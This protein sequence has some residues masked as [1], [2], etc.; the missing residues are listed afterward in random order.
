VLTEA[1]AAV[2]AGGADVELCTPTGAAILAAA[3]TRWQSP[4]ALTPLAVGYGAGDRE[5]ADRPNVLRLTA[6]SPLTS[7]E[8]AV[9]LLEANVDDMSPEIAAHAALAVTAAGA[10]DVWWTP[11]TMKKG[12]PGWV[13]SALTPVAAAAAVERA[14]FAETTTIGVRIAPVERRTAER[15]VVTVETAL[16]AAQIKIATVAGEV[17]NAA[18]E[19]ESC[20][21]LAR[22]AGV[23]LKEAYAA[24]LTAWHGGGA[25]RSD[26]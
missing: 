13:L 26:T 22:A 7:G 1:G 4:P 21:D 6:A 10:L 17:V 14:L 23:P 5:L 9:V 12:R 15:R 18:P 8:A 11:V 24:V 2:R 25:A 16:G 19:Y 20:A 3:V